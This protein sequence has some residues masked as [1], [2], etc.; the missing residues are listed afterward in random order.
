M[1]SE[2]VFLLSGKGKTS[3]F[4]GSDKKRPVSGYRLAGSQSYIA[5]HDLKQFEPLKN[6]VVGRQTKL[7]SHPDG[8]ALKRL[9]PITQL[10]ISVSTHIS[11]GLTCKLRH[12]YFLAKPLRLRLASSSSPPPAP[13]P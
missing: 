4:G 11:R 8:L 1:F 6:A 3:T 10:S 7:K 12:H 13:S 2:R 9:F 5:N